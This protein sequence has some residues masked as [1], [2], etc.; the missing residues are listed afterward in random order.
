MRIADCLLDNF[1]NANDLNLCGS[2]PVVKG[3]ST[4]AP[5]AIL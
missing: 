2:P 1:S 3:A 4:Q 5:F